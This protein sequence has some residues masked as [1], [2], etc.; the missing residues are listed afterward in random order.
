MPKPNEQDLETCKNLMR[1]Y[2]GNVPLTKVIAELRAEADATVKA[3]TTE[4]KK[5]SARVFAH[6]INELR[7]EQAEAIQRAYAECLEI[8]KSCLGKNKISESILL[9]EIKKAANKAKEAK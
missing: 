9:M 4:A 8:A 1:R 2:G 7:A 6:D 5:Q 3:A